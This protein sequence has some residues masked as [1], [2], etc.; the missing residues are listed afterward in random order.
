MHRRNDKLAALGTTLA[1]ISG[2]ETLLRPQLDDI[3]RRIGSHGMISGL[4][5]NGYL[6]TP[7]RIQ[8]LNEAGLDHLQISIDNVQPDG[9]PKKSLKV[10]AQTLQ[11]LKEHAES[12]GKLHSAISA[13]A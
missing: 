2:G 6:L 8:Q 3:I 1:T 11:W 10:L 7:Q 13:A 5:T 12:P 4:I 9:I